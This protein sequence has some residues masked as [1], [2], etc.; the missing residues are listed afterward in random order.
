MLTDGDSYYSN[1]NIM[2]TRD[3]VAEAKSLSRFEFIALFVARCTARKDGR[4][5]TNGLRVRKAKGGWVYGFEGMPASCAP[6]TADRVYDMIRRSAL[7]Y[8]VQQAE[9][10]RAVALG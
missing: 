1:Y 3:V 9:D 10:I 5:M 4:E 6:T 8:Y 2:T 7:N